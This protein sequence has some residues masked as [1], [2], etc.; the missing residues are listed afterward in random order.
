MSEYLF[1][2]IPYLPYMPTPSRLS[3]RG[4]FP[5]QSPDLC[6]MSGEY[7]YDMP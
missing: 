5:L 6:Y 2:K 7:T 3:Q 4:Q 1:E